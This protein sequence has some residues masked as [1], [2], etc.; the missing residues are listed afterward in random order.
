[1]ARTLGTISTRNTG[2]MVG[3]GSLNLTFSGTQNLTGGSETT[4]SY[5]PWR[6]AISGQIDTGAGND[7]LDYSAYTRHYRNHSNCR[8]RK[9]RR[10]S[11]VDDNGCRRAQ[12]GFHHGDREPYDHFRR[13]TTTIIGATVSGAAVNFKSDVASALPPWRFPAVRRSILRRK[14]MTAR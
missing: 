11:P 4:N 14:S 7:T 3:T 1:M 8:R 10:R 12:S 2:S 13:R 6:A 9:Q 5:S